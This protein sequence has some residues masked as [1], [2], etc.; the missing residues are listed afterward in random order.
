MELDVISFLSSSFFFG[1]E[2]INKNTKGN[3]A[4][5]KLIIYSN[6]CMQLLFIYMVV[7]PI[8]LVYFK[9]PSRLVRL[10]HLI[11]ATLTPVIIV[12][13]KVVIV[14]TDVLGFLPPTVL[15]WHLLYA[16]VYC[17]ATYEQY[18]V[19]AAPAGAKRPALAIARSAVLPPPST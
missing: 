14:C 9:T 16:A 10:Q 2:N 4:A 17:V 12:P 19:P 13:N 11:Y 15:S 6:T 5:A 1:F 18:A 8:Y 7:Q 3:A